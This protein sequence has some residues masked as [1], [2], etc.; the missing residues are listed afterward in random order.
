[1]H[2]HNLRILKQVIQVTESERPFSLGTRRVTFQNL[3]AE[4]QAHPFDKTAHMADTDDADGI[5]FQTDGLPGSQAI[6]SRKNI[7]HDSAGIAPRSI[8]DGNAM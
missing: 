1:M 5:A 8:S 7:L 2:R 6:E 3:E 4:R